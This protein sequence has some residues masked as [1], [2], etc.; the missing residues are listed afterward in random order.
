MRVVAPGRAVVEAPRHVDLQRRARAGQ[1]D[2]HEPPLLG[3]LLLRP[4]RHARREVPVVRREQVDR[5]ELQTL[6]RVHRGQHEPVVVEVRRLREVLGR[7]RR[8]EQQLGHERRQRRRLARRADE[9]VEVLEPHG[10]VG[11]VRLDERGQRVAQDVRDLARRRRSAA[12][13]ERREDLAGELTCRGGEVTLKIK[14]YGS[15]RIY[16]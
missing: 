15:Q 6:R 11:V 9:R 5:A 8:I 2:V 4:R 13:L 10:R 12:E 3:D 16:S 1:R 7:G 14:V